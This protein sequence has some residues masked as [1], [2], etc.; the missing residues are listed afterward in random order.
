MKAEALLLGKAVDTVANILKQA[1]SFDVQ[2]KGASKDPETGE[3]A[4]DFVVHL[5]DSGKKLR[6]S[7]RL[8]NKKPLLVVPE[9]SRDLMNNM[10]TPDSKLLRAE[11]MHAQETALNQMED[12][13]KV[14]AKRD[15]YLSTMQDKIKKVLDGFGPL[16]FALLKYT[17]KTKRGK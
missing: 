11:L 7:V 9:E 15:K 14:S 6:F 5:K 8:E 10:A 17:L 3:V 12:V 4:V 2:K 13:A 1:G 16:E